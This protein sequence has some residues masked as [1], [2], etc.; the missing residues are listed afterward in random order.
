M[1]ALLPDILSALQLPYIFSPSRCM[2]YVCRR[3][4]QPYF[5]LLWLNACDAT[6]Q[7]FGAQGVRSRR[8]GQLVDH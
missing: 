3:T 5:S 7:M 4:R 1:A 2:R 8:A 6:S